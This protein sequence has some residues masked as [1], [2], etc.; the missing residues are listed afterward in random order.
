M[1]RAQAYRRILRVVCK[2]PEWRTYSDVEALIAAFKGRGEP[3]FAEVPEC[4][5]LGASALHA[6]AAAL[7]VKPTDHDATEIDDQT[8]ESEHISE[9]PGEGD[10]DAEA[11]QMLSADSSVAGSEPAT[12]PDEEQPK[13]SNEEMVLAKAEMFAAAKRAE[14]KAL[15]DAA[16]AW[17]EDPRRLVLCVYAMLA[18]FS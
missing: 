14:A 3:L 13:L 6:L 4:Q 17:E 18:S 5:G 10:V 11:K 1:Y 15:E 12:S 16:R 7:E 2:A 8:I 9:A